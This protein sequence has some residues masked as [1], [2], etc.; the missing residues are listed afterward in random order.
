MHAK[1]GCGVALCAALQPLGTSSAH[2]CH[3]LLQVARAMNLDAS[4]KIVA[5]GQPITFSVS[6]AQPAPS[7][8]MSGSTTGTLTYSLDKGDGSAP[9]PCSVLSSDATYM[10][11]ALPAMD[12]PGVSVAYSSAGTKS[13]VLRVYSSDRCP[14]G[15]MPPP[16]TPWDMAVGTAT[17]QVRARYMSAQKLHR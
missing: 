15:S 1:A 10:G 11:A 9:S 7:I 14:S 4:A 5:L 8:T 17:I 3:L 12:L 2:A 6:S 13:V 16:D